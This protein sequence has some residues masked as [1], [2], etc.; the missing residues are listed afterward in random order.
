MVFLTFY[1][2]VKEIGGNKILIEDK[3]TK[4]FLDFG[5]S[6]SRRSMF[7]E[8]F[9]TPRV[10]NGIGDFLEMGLLPDIKGIYREDLLKHLGREPEEREVD[11]V[12]LSHAHADHA[13]YISFL[14]KDIPIYCSEITKSVLEAME[15]QSQR[16]IENEILNFKERPLFRKDYNKQP[17]ER[18]FI[19]FKNKEK[20]KIG[21][22]EIIPFYVDH[23]I[24]GASAFIIYT[25]EG[26][27]AYTGDFRLH[28]TNANYTQE[29]IDFVSKEKPIAL[30]IEGT[31]I[32]R[33]EENLPSEK[34]VYERASEVARNTKEA[35][36]VDFNFKDADRFRTFF[37]IAKEV[38]RKLVISFRHA[39]F[40]ERYHKHKELEVP[41]IQDENIAIFKPKLGTGT[42]S[43][44]DY[45][46]YK[47]IKNRLNYKNIITAEEI[48]NNQRKYMIVL[49][50]YSF[51]NLIDIRPNSGSVYIHSLS[52][53]INEEME[54][55]E[56]RMD[57]WLRH[58]NL[59]KYQ[60]H[61]SGHASEED[62]L[63]VVKTINPKILFPI[64]TEYPGFFSRMKIGCKNK[65]VKEKVRYKLN[66]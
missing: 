51:N 66:H 29:F 20:Y 40:L 50:F 36:I 56:K 16:D 8:E 17:I 3:D 53:A 22:L 49:N 27:I 54:I 65:I 47:F 28:G 30:I 4:V 15:E 58:F 1:G 19:V 6:F 61:C 31:N 39:C 62:L 59:A 55:S 7:F 60:I 25:S 14:H 45:S 9:L 32:K 37:K 23:S 42:Y 26:A 12:L 57:N 46:G 38:E 2:G 48:R 43:D 35:L 24:P 64:H 41:S 21:S 5:I 10:A 11:A 34:I 52:E 63:Y 13:N 33:R 44:E 18:K